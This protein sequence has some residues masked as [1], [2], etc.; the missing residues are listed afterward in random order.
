[1]LSDIQKET[2]RRQ[3]IAKLVAPGEVQTGNVHLKDVSVGIELE[4]SLPCS[5]VLTLASLR[6]ALNLEKA[7][8]ARTSLLCNQNYKRQELKIKGDWLSLLSLEMIFNCPCP[9]R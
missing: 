6:P 7:E 4:K 5:G 1:M 3:E 8:L 9:P 2:A